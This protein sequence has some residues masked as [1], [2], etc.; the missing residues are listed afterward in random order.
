MLEQLAAQNM[1]LEE[2]VRER[3]TTEQALQRAQENLELQV[4]QRTGE[5][6]AVNEKLR[7]EIADHMLADEALRESEERFQRMADAIPEV[8]WITDLHPETML[9]VS[10]SF[11][12]IWGR[13]I[14]DLYR[15]PR[16]WIQAI[17]PED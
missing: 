16:L 17:H 1:R 6:V 12:T 2:E 15:N 9:Y 14:E 3:R 11:A 8:I 13:P 5:L 7:K 4:S 10:P